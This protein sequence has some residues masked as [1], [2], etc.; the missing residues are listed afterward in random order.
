MPRSAEA[1][2]EDVVESCEA[3]ETAILGVNTEG[4]LSSRLLRSAVE[5]EFLI[6]GEAVVALG[7]LEPELASRISHARL[8]VGFRNRLAHEYSVI[9]DDAVLRI[10]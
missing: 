8:I 4:Y 9:D 1:Y 6:V 5:R 10:A 2:L 7:R 3:I